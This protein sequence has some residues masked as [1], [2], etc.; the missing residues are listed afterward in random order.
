[1]ANHLGVSSTYMSQVLSGSKTLTLEQALE[2][3]QYIG[4]S[5]IESEYFLIMIQT[6]RAG[7]HRLKE[8]FSQ[9]LEELKR[10]SLKLVNRVDAK[11]TLNDQEKSIFYSNALYSA[12]HIYCATYKKGR[13]VEEISQRFDLPRQRVTEIL[14][15]L[16]ETNLCVEADGRFLTGTQ[17]THLEQG[18][19]HLI[20]HYTN[21]RLR[22]LQA[23]ESL[24]E[25]ELMYTM[26]IAL[27]E[28]DFVLLREEMV[29]FIKSFLARALPSSS[30]EIACFNMDWFWIRK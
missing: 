26:N 12:I 30:E 14:R 17:S 22:S 29:Q 25:E 16:T 1:M 13:S 20:K 19:P 27:S 4:L 24:R 23:A 21:W 8:H 5:S 28:K 6:E 11:R 15:F 3:G 9:K 10:K 18:S 2:L 7:T